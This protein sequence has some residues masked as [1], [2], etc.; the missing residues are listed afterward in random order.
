MEEKS[1][2]FSLRQKKSSRRPPISAPQQVSSSS[3]PSTTPLARV[4]GYSDE[5]SG[6]KLGPGAERDIIRNR[7]KLGGGT[8][9]LVK[10]RYSTRFTNLPDFSNGATPPVPALPGSS[11]HPTKENFHSTSL[12]S[13]IDVD[14]VSLRDQALQAEKCE[15]SLT[16]PYPL[17]GGRDLLMDDSDATNL[18]LDASNQELR[19]YQ[20]NLQMIKA[21]TSANLQQK[22]YQNRTQFIQI[23][24][25]ADK[26]K[27]EMRT[28]R[29]LMSELT[30]SLGQ[31]STSASMSETRLKHD[32]GDSSAR[33]HANR[34]SVA[35]L[36]A[37]WNVQLHALWKN[38]EGSQ[39]FLPAVPGRHVLHESG[40]WVELDAA[41]WK[42]RRPAH[43]FLL[44]DHLLVG[45]KKRKRTDPN[46]NLDGAKTQTPMTKLVADRC[47][48]LQDIDIIDITSASATSDR[49]EML[50]AISIRYGNESF[51][52][53]SDKQSSI[54][55][56]NLLLA[57]RRAADEL[58]RSLQDD[59]DETKNKAHSTTNHLATRDPVLFKNQD[60]VEANS[61][62]KDRTET[63]IEVDG[64]HQNFR[65]VEG[66]IDEL[67]SEIA[68][69]RFEDAVRHI[70]KLRRMPRG[71]KSSMVA[72]ELIADKVDERAGRLAG[73]NSRKSNLMKASL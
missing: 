4:N 40:N 11:N 30:A 45:S 70:E 42:A 46:A 68:L 58:R 73:I 55:K 43:I 62:S 16:N 44:N 35:N 50:N 8:S 15:E 14:L 34:S 10:R 65:W 72:L 39:K 60:L 22:V 51:T 32:N 20:A 27:E 26:L 36:E 64:K 6:G 19:E 57:F 28:L 9:D 7:P 48:P 49:E 18:L 25:E 31:A 17:V 41:T 71:L 1:R 29:N 52:Y 69:Q 33:K 5:S 67:D 63:F 54:Q 59:V 37:M 47:W 23:S 2:G 12:L 3:N 21:R 24:K 53:R 61:D 56:A 66:Q 38:V 13:R